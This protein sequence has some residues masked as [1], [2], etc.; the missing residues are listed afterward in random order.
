MNTTIWEV[1]IVLVMYGV[2]G[3]GEAV[4]IYYPCYFGKSD[5]DF[6]KFT[7]CLGLSGT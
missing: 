3:I 6:S 1:T 5:E 4:L 2:K 7:K